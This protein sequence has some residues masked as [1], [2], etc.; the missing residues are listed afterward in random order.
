MGMLPNLAE[1][2]QVKLL[3]KILEEL[4]AINANLQQGS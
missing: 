1:A 3:T 2:Q 4:K